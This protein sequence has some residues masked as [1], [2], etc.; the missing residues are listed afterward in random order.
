MNWHLPV[1]LLLLSGSCGAQTSGNATSSGPCSPAVS[2][3]NNSFSIECNGITKQQYQQFL[4]ILNK[5]ARN[6]IP[7]DKVMEKLDEIQHDVETIK[8]NTAGRRLTPEQINSLS[9]ALSPLKG[10]SIEILSQISD[11]DGSVYAQDF[12]QAFK[13]AGIGNGGEGSGIAQYSFP[14]KGVLVS[15]NKHDGEANT[16]PADALV[17]SQGLKAIGIDVIGFGDTS[18]ENGTA[19]LVIGLKSQ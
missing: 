9:A 15:I 2:G 17:L 5:I 6:D 12:V 10:H 16:I 18:Q 8:K 1:L 3:S 13:Q 11:A 14:L 19:K 4:A 7:A